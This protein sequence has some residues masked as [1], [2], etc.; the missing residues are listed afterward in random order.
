M[1]E[2]IEIFADPLK[3]EGE[4]VAKVDLVE[5]GSKLVAKEMAEVGTAG[6]VWGCV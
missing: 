3:D 4:W 5:E 1:I 2:R 6:G